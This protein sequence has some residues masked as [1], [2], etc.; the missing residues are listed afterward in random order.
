MRPGALLSFTVVCHVLV[1]SQTKLKQ[2]SVPKPPLGF[3]DREKGETDNDIGGRADL[4][5]R[6]HAKFR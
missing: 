5:G 1:L 6:G 3:L 4:K 2:S